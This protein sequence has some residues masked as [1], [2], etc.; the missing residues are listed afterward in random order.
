MA[1]GF[2]SV[3]QHA[4]QQKRSLVPPEAN[5][6]SSQADPPRGPDALLQL[7]TNPLIL[8]ARFGFAATGRDPSYFRRVV[9]L[10][11]GEKWIIL[12][13]EGLSAQS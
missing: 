1:K 8:S 11:S 10:L 6:S 3:A 9:A 4:S 12:E 13:G 5:A 2:A 7:P